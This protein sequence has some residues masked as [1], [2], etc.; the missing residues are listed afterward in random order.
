MNGALGLFRDPA[1]IVGAVRT[2][3][4]TQSTRVTQIATTIAVQ[5]DDLLV[6]TQQVVT[7]VQRITRITQVTKLIKDYSE[8]VFQFVGLVSTV[9]PRLRDDL[10][11]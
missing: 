10:N 7:T 9:L 2:T 8:K 4:I 5:A 11:F 1:K 3:N 6:V